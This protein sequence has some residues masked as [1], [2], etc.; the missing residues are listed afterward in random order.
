[1]KTQLNETKRMQQLAGIIK[2]SEIDKSIEEAD[3]TPQEISDEQFKIFGGFKPSAE[4]IM[5]LLITQ[6][7]GAQE[8]NDLMKKYGFTKWD[9]IQAGIKL[10]LQGMKL[11]AD[12]KGFKD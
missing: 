2:E 4:K 5:R 7:I 8:A 1:M 12:F 6:K 9:M 11:P 10:G 3:V